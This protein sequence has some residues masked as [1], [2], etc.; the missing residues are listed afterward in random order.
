[1]VETLFCVKVLF[2]AITNIH[3]VTAQPHITIQ[4]IEWFIGVKTLL[5]SKPIVN[6]FRKFKGA[7]WTWLR[8]CE[9]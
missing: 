3:L 1:M 2:N 7:S 5:S 8:I 6:H 4:F 9:G